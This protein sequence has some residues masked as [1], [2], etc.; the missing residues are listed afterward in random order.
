M[1]NFLRCCPEI[2]VR[3]AEVLSLSRVRGFTGRI[4][5]IIIIIITMSKNSEV[6]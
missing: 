3:T 2:S 5:I 6:K 1:E 4:I